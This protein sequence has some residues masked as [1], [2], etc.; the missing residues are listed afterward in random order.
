ML[1]VHNGLRMSLRARGGVMS[2]GKRVEGDY[3]G[4]FPSLR[5]LDVEEASGE[6]ALALW[7]LEGEVKAVVTP[8]VISVGDLALR[9]VVNQ[10]PGLLLVWSEGDSHFLALHNGSWHETSRAEWLEHMKAADPV[11]L[12]RRM[13]SRIV[14]ALHHD[15]ATF[16]QGRLGS[17]LIQVLDF[18]FPRGDIYLAELLQNAADEDANRISIRLD[19]REQRLTLEHDGRPFNPTDVLGL[20]LVGRSAKRHATIGFMGIGFK[21]VFKRFTRARVRDAIWNFHFDYGDDH[22]GQLL[23]IWEEAPS[24]AEPSNGYRVQI[25]L[26]NPRGDFDQV[27]QDVASLPLEVPV[28]LGRRAITRPGGPEIWRLQLGRRDIQVRATKQ[29]GEGNGK[30]LMAT[31]NGENRSWCFVSTAFTPGARAMA[32]YK[33]HRGS[34]TRPGRQEVSLFFELNSGGRVAHPNR[35]QV[36]AVLPTGLASPVHCHLQANWLPSVDRQGLLALRDSAWNQE[37]VNQLPLLL[38]DMLEQVVAPVHGTDLPGLYALLPPL[39][40]RDGAPVLPFHDA[41]V[42]MAPLLTACRDRPLVPVLADGPDADMGSAVAEPAGTVDGPAAE[43]RAL[44]TRP[45]GEPQVRGAKAQEAVAVPRPLWSS[46]SPEFLR[47]WLGRAVFAAEV[48]GDGQPFWDSTGVVASLDA[49]MID[50]RR[51]G[52]LTA[53][54][55]LSSEKAKVWAHILVLSAVKDAL[56]EKLL[57]DGQVGLADLPLFPTGNGALAKGLGCKLLEQDLFTA[58]EEVQEILLD[59]VTGSDEEGLLDYSLQCTLHEPAPAGATE[60]VRR[61]QR[62]LRTWLWSS[63]KPCKVVS[64]G[65]LLTRFFSRLEGRDL[66]D[67]ERRKVLLVS[68]WT[69]ANKR[70]DLSHVLVDIQGGIRVLPREEAFLGNAYG[71]SVLQRAAG[72]SLPFVSEVYKTSPQ[73]STLVSSSR[74]ADYFQRTLGLPDDSRVRPVWR[75]VQRLPATNP[76]SPQDRWPGWSNEQTRQSHLELMERLELKML[77]LVRTTDWKVR[78]PHDLGD[79]RNGEFVEARPDFHPALRSMIASSAEDLETARGIAFLIGSNAGGW[80]EDHKG[81]CVFYIDHNNA[82]MMTKEVTGEAAP[83][84]ELLR[85]SRWLPGS[86]LEVHLPAELLVRPDPSMPEVPHLLLSDDAVRGLEALGPLIGLGSAVVPLPPV[87]RLERYA[88]NPSINVDQL[89]RAW[90]KVVEA[91]RVKP[92]ELNLEERRKVQDLARTHAL[93]PVGPRRGGGG[94]DRVTSRQMVQ[95]TL[96]NRLGGWLH[97]LQDKDCPL[98]GLADDIATLLDMPRRADGDNALA[99][100]EDSWSSRPELTRTTLGALAAAYNL[101][102]TDLEESNAPPWRPAFEHL[103][104]SGK[105][106]L[107]CQAPGSDQARWYRFPVTE[108]P[109]P[110]LNDDPGRARL[111][112]S[113]HGYT[114]E[115]VLPRL[116]RRRQAAELADLFG[117][118]RLSGPNFRVS[119]EPIN[120]RPLEAETAR[121]SQLLQLAQVVVEGDA[122][123]DGGT[124]VVLRSSPNLLLCEGLT[125]TLTLDRGDGQQKHAV[126]AAWDGKSLYLVGEARDYYRPLK[127]EIRCH[128]QLDDRPGLGALLDLLPLLDDEERFGAELAEVRRELGLADAQEHPQPTTA[129]EVRPPQYEEAAEPDQQGPTDET[130][131]EKH[132]EPESPTAKAAGSAFSPGL[133]LTEDQVVAEANDIRE[134][135]KL[136]SKNPQEWSRTV[137]NATYEE[138]KDLEKTLLL[139]P[140][141]R[142]SRDEEDDAD[143]PRPKRDAEFI[144]AVIKF[145]ASQ[146]PPRYAVGKDDP[147]PARDSNPGH[148]IDSFTHQEGHPNRHLIRRIEVK[149]TRSAWYDED[150]GATGEAIVEMSSRQ[151]ADALHRELKEIDGVQRHPDFDYWL[152]VVEKRR[153]SVFRIHRVKNPARKAKKY[154]VRGSLWGPLAESTDIKM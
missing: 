111:L 115:S 89:V 56:D 119:V 14:R 16:L 55:V 142:P 129:A 82:W 69:C 51:K 30:R 110:L 122:A 71:G 32:N 77:P 146:D 67:E 136:L 5:I 25:E 118:D 86:D 13:A 130:K 7:V 124:K 133:G 28:L 65:R 102:A 85:S 41:D 29:D 10:P 26:S 15:N 54:G 75:I 42:A 57:D 20:C 113:E 9:M 151:F 34:A 49:G 50:R 153:D 125:R 94:A 149:G 81:P 68:A 74:W 114:F 19:A 59:Q 72:L 44:V 2:F 66:T 22:S 134:R 8:R 12:N 101:L 103:R 100:L 127:E 90:E 121:F 3:L 154:A 123:D 108:P 17:G 52:L 141:P 105:V 91:Y 112:R 106:L 39:Q 128:L 109:L 92:S 6:E 60:E 138:L 36:Y 18:T 88:D 33:K 99:F 1:E 97:S 46:V 116:K 120:P 40:T 84:I 21:S 70:E 64:L 148:D 87:E 38:A 78:L 45:A 135:L 35:P 61:A 73:T 126:R 4:Q 139:T 79:L 27:E 137:E 132:Q 11:P 104:D 53:L 43:A 95:G 150:G 58:P 152:Y 140:S 96:K 98:N 23:P 131:A 48:V 62:S 31:C 80:A 37:I 145:E 76:P 117:L 83:W 144:A 24:G 147:D 107:P 47:K 93:L 143:R 63:D